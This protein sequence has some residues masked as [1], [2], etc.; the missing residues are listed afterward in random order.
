MYFITQQAQSLV[1]MKLLDH[2]RVHREVNSLSFY[3]GHN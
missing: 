2:S 3:K 1:K